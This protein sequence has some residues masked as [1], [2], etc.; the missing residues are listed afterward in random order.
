MNLRKH[1]AKREFIINTEEK[2]TLGMQHVWRR[3]CAPKYY[4]EKKPYSFKEHENAYSQIQN[5]HAPESLYREGSLCCMVWLSS[6]IS[7]RH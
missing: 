5:L 1:S 3:I 7:V 2:Q 4:S 6:K